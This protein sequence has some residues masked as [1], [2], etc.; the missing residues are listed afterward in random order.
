MT[1][2][3]I[4]GTTKPAAGP[5]R[6][7]APLHGVRPRPNGESIRSG[8]LVLGAARMEAEAACKR[9][10]LR[11]S[12]SRKYATELRDRVAIAPEYMTEI[13]VGGELVP[14]SIM[15]E[16]S[17]ALQFADT[18]QN[19]NYVTVDASRDR[20]DLAHEAAALESALDAADSIDAK[21]SL[22]KMLAH[23]LAAGHR[24][25]MKLV[26]EVNRQ[27][28]YLANVHG[29]EQDRMNVQ[30]TRL[31][32]AT[33]RMMTTFQQ[34]LVTL[35]RLRTGGQQVVT[36]QHVGVR[37][38]GQAIVGGRM[39]AGGGGRQAN[40]RPGQKMTDLPHAH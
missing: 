28:S 19:P 35:Q 31:A 15:G 4:P 36:V 18:V 21:N 24:S 6:S 2:K 12:F 38:G 23:Q 33:A 29:S 34:G 25:A 5:Q 37:D 7:R 1:N 9:D 8:D 30:V 32:G 3:T 40:R 20:L 10:D 26:A 16:N 14:A 27:A 17:R 13:G 22:E 39:K 11:N